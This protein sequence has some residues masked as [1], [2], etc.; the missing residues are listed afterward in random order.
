[1]N[2]RIFKTYTATLFIQYTKALSFS[3]RRDAGRG[4]HNAR[5]TKLKHRDAFLYSR[6]SCTASRRAGVSSGY[7]EQYY[8]QTVA[9]VVATTAATIAAAAAASWKL[10]AYNSRRDCFSA[11]RI[12]RGTQQTR[13]DGTKGVARRALVTSARATSRL[14]RP[15]QFRQARRLIVLAASYEP[16]LRPCQ[17]MTSGCDCRSLEYRQFVHDTALPAQVAVSNDHSRFPNDHVR[18]CVK[19]LLS[20]HSIL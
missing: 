3:A 16:A 1:M 6:A 18:C 8:W 4:Q 2:G 11:R 15:W 7:F 19:T 13:R 20:V 9:A 5:R 14:H 17:A 10:G 12:G